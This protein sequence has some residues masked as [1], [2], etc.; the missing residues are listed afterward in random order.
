MLKVVAL[1][2]ISFMCN[3][4]FA[5]NFEQ[6]AIMNFDMW[7]YGT[8]KQI[9]YLPNYS[10]PDEDYKTS[11]T[12]NSVYYKA[13]YQ[14]ES[15]RYTFSAFN[16]SEGNR[17]VT[18]ADVAY[19]VN[20]KLSA[21]IGI[22]PFRVSQ[23]RYFETNNVWIS[24]PDNFCKFHGLNE[25]SEGAAGVQLGYSSN[26]KDYIVDTLVGYYDAEIDGQSEKLSI[27][28]PVGHNKYNKKWGLS[29][30]A[31]GKDSQISLG[32]LHTS[33]FQYDESGVKNPF[34]RVL[35]YDT[36]YF[37]YEKDI[38]DFTVRATGSA[39]IGKGLGDIRPIDFNA[40]SQTYEISYKLNPKLS[41]NTFYA[42]YDSKT[43]YYPDDI[44][45][46]KTQSLSVPSSG[47]SIRW[48]ATPK[49]FFILQVYKTK[50]DSVTTSKVR[51]VD[52]TTAVGLRWGTLFG[53]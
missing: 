12:F 24:E 29:S 11:R 26:I 5:S 53:D 43:E 48:N 1:L 27:Y 44:K 25:I 49:T 42:Q 45:K 19:K 21:S 30:R 9:R 46:F 16:V 51:T 13:S 47:A 17:K 18:R 39:Y 31:I 36:L 28:V 7:D 35:E 38:E 37:G 52:G 40:I 3:V 20:D 6:S 33:Q 14:S 23:C 50:S 2:I 10:T 15:M 34:D 32:Y 8:D 41:F 4:V 22:L